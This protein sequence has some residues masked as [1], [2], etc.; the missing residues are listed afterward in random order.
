[1]AQQSNI[2]LAERLRPRT[3]DDYI[4]Q[5]HLVG[6]GGVFRKFIETGNVP[7]FILWGPP[8]VGKTTL[9]RLV[10]GALDRK[11]FTLSAINSGVK[12]VREVI[13]QARKQKF[14]N[15]P[16]PFLFIDEIH[17]FNKAQQDSLLGAVEQGDITL[18]GATTENPSFEVISPL[19]SRCQVYVLKAMDDAQLQ[20]LLDRA[21]STDAILRERHIE[22]RETGALF[23]FAGGD[24]RKLLNILDIVAGASDGD[25]H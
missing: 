5:E 20:E 9:A 11:M 4:G 23:G 6:P 17:R 15:T 25:L 22:V 8:G 12:D 21:L 7:S 24:A 19:L 1:M 13:E 16:A 2:P 14:F 18:V 3:L 10:A